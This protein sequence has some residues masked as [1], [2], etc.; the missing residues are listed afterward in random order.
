MDRLRNRSRVIAFVLRFAFDWFF[1]DEEYVE[2]AQ[3]DLKFVE[4]RVYRMTSNQFKQN[5]RMDPDTF[6]DL[7]TKLQEVYTQQ[8]GHPEISLQKSALLTIWYIGNMESF[9]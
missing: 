8:R 9:R 2:D 4:E 5:F 7:L 1:D 6:E 3:V